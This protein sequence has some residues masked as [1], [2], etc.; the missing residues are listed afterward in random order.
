MEQ[1]TT[2]TEIPKK[3]IST[4]IRDGK[5]YV[6]DPSKMTVG[7]WEA[8]E[9]ELIE[10]GYYDLMR[11]YTEFAA[12]PQY[13]T[14]K[15]DP[16]SEESMKEFIKLRDLWAEFN[17][18]NIEQGKE[19]EE[20]K[21]AIEYW[22]RRLKKESKFQSILQRVHAGL[23]KSGGRLRMIAALLTPEGKTYSEET[24]NTISED[25][26][27]EMTRKEAEDVLSNFLNS[28]ELLEQLSL[29]YMR[30]YTPQPVPLS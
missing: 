9:K 27:P 18:G 13:H 6:Y 14:K 1:A 21:A 4:I 17:Q 8:A 20:M 24:S 28:S 3:N 11:E 25:I 29:N 16:K 10:I 26:I 23:I 22:T 19:S 7:Q 12:L 2:T 15:Y 5:K 30:Q